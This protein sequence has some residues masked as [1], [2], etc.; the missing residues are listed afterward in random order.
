MK[1]AAAGFADRRRG[2]RQSRGYGAEWDKLRLVILQRD[3]YRCRLCLPR[4]TAAHAVDHIV[5]KHLGGTDEPSNLQAIC[6][7]CHDAK[8]AAEALAARGITEMRPS[9]AC[10]ASG[11]PT[12]PRHPW[13]PRGGAAVLQAV[14][15][16]TV[17]DHSL[18]RCQNGEGG[19]SGG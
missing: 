12:D 17:R 13:A 11:L 1:T 2:S 8:T 9:A 19:A 4:V 3:L 5:P 14:A 10:A 16:R 7:P 18:A 6:K 15:Q